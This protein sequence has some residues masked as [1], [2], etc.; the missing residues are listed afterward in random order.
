MDPKKPHYERVDADF[1]IVIKGLNYGKHTLKLSHNTDTNSRSYEQKKLNDAGSLG[2]LYF[3][4]LVAKQDL[5][6]RVMSLYRK[7]GNPSHYLIEID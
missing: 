5:L 1:D 3:L 4:K 6:G 2:Q 7:N